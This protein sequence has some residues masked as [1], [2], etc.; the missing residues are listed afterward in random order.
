MGKRV[1]GGGVR[2]AYNDYRT[3]GQA[4]LPNPKGHHTTGAVNVKRHIHSLSSLLSFESLVR[5]KSISG[6]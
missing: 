2:A 4:V 5:R 1:R 6:F 3:K